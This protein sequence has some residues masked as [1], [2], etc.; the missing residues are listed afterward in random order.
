MSS[1]YLLDNSEALAYLRILFDIAK[2]VVSGVAKSGLA[3]V[4][5]NQHAAAGHQP[6][7]ALNTDRSG[8][9]PNRDSYSR[10][11]GKVPQLPR[12]AIS[13]FG[14]IGAT[15][16]A[17]ELPQQQL[18]APDAVSSFGMVIKLRD[19]RQSLCLVQARKHRRQLVRKFVRNAISPN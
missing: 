15:A 4:Q 17:N 13:C 3:S 6:T 19:K 18:V 9:A 2:L 16:L 8:A 12:I 10:A 1:Q 5:R 11:T 14:A 7:A